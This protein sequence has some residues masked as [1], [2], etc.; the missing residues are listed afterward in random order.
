MMYKNGIQR[1]GGRDVYKTNGH[2]WWTDWAEKSG[3]GVM[4]I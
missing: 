1:R 4:T 3:K 2:S